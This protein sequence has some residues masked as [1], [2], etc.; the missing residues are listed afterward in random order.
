MVIQH[1]HQHCL[2]S[3]RA[4]RV[5]PQVASGFVI[6]KPLGGFGCRRAEH[7][8]VGSQLT[9]VQRLEQQMVQLN[10]VRERQ[11]VGD[12]VGLGVA[13]KPE[14]V[15]TRATGQGVR[16]LAACQYVV[17][18]TAQQGVVTGATSEL[19]VAALAVQGVVAGGAFEGVAGGGEGQ[20]AF[21]RDFEEASVRAMVVTALVFSD[22]MTLLGPSFMRNASLMPLVA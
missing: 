7:K 17:A 22:A 11:E 21:G 3:A 10:A 20:Y 1:T 19:V 14:G 8:M 2:N 12:V 18:R 9:R 15:C 6:H 13:T 5:V 4:V 16:T